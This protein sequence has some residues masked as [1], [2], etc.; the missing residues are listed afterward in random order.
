ML[1]VLVAD[2]TYAMTIAE[3]EYRS[4]PLIEAV[5]ELFIDGT[6]SDWSPRSFERARKHFLDFS[7]QEER[8]EPYN[9]QMRVGPGKNFSHDFQAAPQRLRWWDTARQRAVQFG[10][11]MC[12]YNVLPQAYGH[13]DDHLDT[14]RAVFSFFLEEARPSSVTWIG[15]RYINLIKVPAGAD[16]VSVYFDI[17]PRFPAPLNLGHRPFSLQAQVVD[18]EQGNVQIGLHLQELARET[19]N[20][21]L[22]VYARSNGPVASA[23]NDLVDWQRIAHKRVSETFEL[24]ISNRS[25]DELFG[26]KISA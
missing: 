25:R 23:T 22:D 16:D 11:N 7:G 26:R 4:P 8:L 6:G 20:Y 24:C 14:L 9:I 15:Q 3:P 21:V 19:A 5:F 12:A 10:S 18:F 17:Y 2:D 13:F 1:E